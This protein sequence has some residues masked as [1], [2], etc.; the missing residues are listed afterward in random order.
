MHH[1]KDILSYKLK[2][3]FQQLVEASKC[4]YQEVGI[5]R[6]NYV[7][8]H[9]IY[10]QPGITQAELAE[11]SGADRNVITKMIDKLEEKQYVRRERNTRDRRS[12]SLYLTP[13]G[14]KIVHDYWPT[15]IQDEQD[16]L[17]KLSPQEQKLFV[18][19]LEKLMKN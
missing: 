18:D 7:K 15:F 2:A 14:E 5:T 9:L 10:E 4:I 11:Q 19:M 16:C 17:N 3:V 6:A 1:I 8:M 12:F 13:E